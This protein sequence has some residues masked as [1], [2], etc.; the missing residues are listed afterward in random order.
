MKKEEFLKDYNTKLQDL[1]FNLKQDSKSFNNFLNFWADNLGNQSFNN[2]MMLFSYRPNGRIFATFDEWNSDKINRR[3]KPKSKGI[4]ILKN[5]R[6]IHVFE[7]S[8][9]YGKKYSIWSNNREH[10]RQ[11]VESYNKIYNKN[12]VDLE[13]YSIIQN[14]ITKNLIDDY[15]DLSDDDIKVISH[16]VATI[17]CMRAKY[18]VSV[19]N[20]NFL[21]SL[22]FNMPNK[23]ILK[24]YQII[25][26]ESINQYSVLY[27]AL[28]DF[29]KNDTIKVKNNQINNNK[30]SDDNV[31]KYVNI[32]LVDAF[33]RSSKKEEIVDVLLS[34]KK[35]GDKAKEIKSLFFHEKININNLEDVTINYTPLLSK[36]KIYINGNESTITWVKIVEKLQMLYFLGDIEFQKTKELELSKEKDKTDTVI[37]S[38]SAGKP[39]KVMESDNSVLVVENYKI[40]DDIPDSFNHRNIIDNNVKA[41]SLLKRLSEEQRHA[42]NE[43]QAIL[44]KYSG[45]GGVP[46]FFDESDSKYIN[47]RDEL[48]LLLSDKE[49]S[50][51]KNTVLTSFYTPT[52][53]ID[54]I[55]YALSK[56]GFNQGNILEPSCGIGRFFGRLPNKFSKSNLYGVEVDNI[57]AKMAKELYPQAKIEL[58]GYEDTNFPNNFFDVA[59]GNVPFGNFTIYD[60]TY[61]EKTIIHDYFFKKTLDKV[62]SGGIIAFI[63]HSGTMDKKD[64]KTRTY[65][66]ERAKLIGAIRLPNNVFFDISGTNVMTDIIFLQKRDDIIKDVSDEAWINVEKYNFGVNDNNDIY[67]NEYYLKHSDMLLGEYNI[68][69]TQWGY[70]SMLVEN[71]YFDDLLLKAIMSLPSDIYTNPLFEITK[72][73]SVYPIFPADPNLKND[74]FIL[75]E[76]DCKEVIYQQQ[77]SSL[78][79]YQNQIGN[80][81][82]RIKGLVCIKHD[83]KE[84]FEVQLKNCSDDELKFYQKK[85]SDNY[86]NFVSKF[87]YINSSVNERVFVEDPDYYLIASIEIL[88]KNVDVDDEKY[89]KSSIFNQRTIKLEPE[90]KKVNNVEQ[91]LIMSLS[92]RSCVDLEYMK[93][94]YDKNIDEIISELGEKIYQDPSKVNEVNKGW[95]TSS[96]YLS[97]NVKEKLKIVKEQPFKYEK[98]I[99]ALEKIIPKDI[100]IENIGIK[101]GA[102]WI[103]EDIYCE[104]VY[105][106]LDI[107]YYDRTK[108]KILW[109]PE[110]NMWLFEASGLYGYSSKNT[111]I[112]GTERA[113]A[114]S[115]INGLLNLSSVVVYDK[116][117]DVRV[118]NKQAT[119]LAREKQQKIC[120]E[121]TNWIFNN[122]DISNRLEKIYNDK[123]NC[124]VPRK[125]SG[126]FLK[127]NGM[128]ENIELKPHQKDAV[129]RVLYGGNTLLAHVVG[130]GKT[131]ECIAS[132]ME[133]RRLSLATKP[134]IVV[135]N[136]LVNQWATEFF[137]LYPMANILVATDKQLSKKNRKKFLSK[138]CTGNWDAVI[139]SHS[140]FGMIPMSNEYNEEFIQLRINE[141]EKAIYRINSQPF[142][143][144][145]ISVKKL[146]GMKSRYETKLKQLMDMPKEN[147][148]TF[149]ETGVDTLFVDEAHMFKNLELTTKLHNVGGISSAFSQRA[150]DLHMK[151][152]YVEQSTNYRG[153]IVLATGTPISNSMCE[154]YSFQKFLQSR[155][156]KELGIDTFD[157]WASTF[158]EVVSSFEVTPIGTGYR[159]KTRFSRFNNIPE[160]M[161]IFYEVA[162][163]KTRNM[164]N[165]KLPKLA[166]NKKHTIVAKRSEELAYIIESLAKRLERVDSVNPQEDNPLVITNDGRKAALDIRVYDDSLPDISYSKVN[167]SVRNV[168][169]IWEKHKEKRSTQV[170]FSDLSTPQLNNDGGFDIYNDMKK[171][172]INL[173][174]PEKEIAFIHNYKTQKSKQKLYEKFRRGEI[175]ILFGSTSK[176]GTGANIQDKL[177]AIHHLDCPWQPA[178]ID[179]R[180][181]RAWRTGN[182]NEEIYIFHY[183]TEQSFDAYSYQLVE[184]K[185]RFI[186]QIMTGNCVQRTAEDIDRETLSYAEIKAI[187]T[188]NP[189]IIEKYKIENKLKDLI[190]SK[191][192]YNKVQGE[193]REKYEITIPNILN[194][195]NNKIKKLE[196]DLE[197]VEDLSSSN[198]MIIL[199]G[200]KYTSRSE[201]SKK[202]FELYSDLPVGKEI[203]IGM[204]SNFEIIGT[205][206]EVIFKP[207]IYLLGQE[208]YKVEVD[209]HENLGNIIKI[210]NILK[211]IPNKIVDLKNKVDYNLKELD[212]I[213][214]ELEK[215]FEHEDLLRNLEKRK[216]EIDDKLNLNDNVIDIDEVSKET[217]L[218]KQN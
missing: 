15:Y 145:K 175:R 179:Q 14:A 54:S 128:S 110:T 3:I 25:N 4:P 130:A 109:V 205:K 22:S 206:D 166:E 117:G 118:V 68:G 42:T 188:G 198:F 129:A 153:R 105:D 87:G 158:G 169:N 56:F 74:E 31:D 85:L 76:I 194:G 114:L 89:V 135:P 7:L 199:N 174:V 192:N 62:R 162:D 49:Y 218:S 209:Y 152:N 182:E 119:F 203:Q 131:F 78:I 61:R 102:T 75:K 137:R 204:I 98:N 201:A 17:V 48:K 161:S 157:E 163:I 10:D 96:E 173:G 1:L 92:N 71:E 21:Y 216:V 57:V 28:I 101:F 51:A 88:D 141:I 144:N 30:L 140:V 214:L 177:V 143:H 106:L 189:L 111:S 52:K 180:D 20:K 47:Y 16:G 139:I 6:V 113:D 134:M 123:Y 26:R 93:T 29:I 146:E 24:C 136:N 125:Y 83:L 183:I 127:F 159:M 184:N 132:A 116:N 112:W 178:Y 2:L 77:D 81:A 43:E 37:S 171:K 41:I 40:M 99:R 9:T 39:N 120:S 27:S 70:K 160:L 124:I 103:P 36:F 176:I 66:A 100:L 11:L 50:T 122:N 38:S 94:L 95:V 165:L 97:G 32:V 82:E 44:A 187:A 155:R 108:L 207:V 185:A 196:K 133:L 19:E 73:N 150:N 86:N 147:I 46:E 164:L 107:A 35:N 168:Y 115:L 79:P 33:E 34:N 195:L 210:E 65:I 193:Y 18:K 213:K 121:F 148:I 8:Q 156:L 142:K 45:W 172:L 200:C 138:I 181:G 212:N 5:D 104:F 190:M 53:I 191:S 186:N 126:E 202:L 60:K 58:N 208:K 63:T 211:S 170:V 91:A 72:Q 13:I 197:M 64:S 67:I 23:Q 80:V 167:L 12:T 217:D 55:Y 90:I 154:L 215:G 151:I 84:L 149:E 69:L 59:I